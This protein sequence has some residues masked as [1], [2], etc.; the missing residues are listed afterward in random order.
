[1][2]RFTVMIRLVHNASPEKGD[3]LDEEALRW[4]VRLSSGETTRDDHEDFRSW[5]DQSASHA[6]ALARART[7][8]L[9]L[10]TAMPILEQRQGWRYGLRRSVVQLVAVAAVLLLCVNLGSQYWFEWRFDHVTAPGER[11]LLTLADG[12]RILM[13]GGTALNI[14]S[15]RGVRRIELSR[16][17]AL[18]GVRHDPHTP[19]VVNAG[20]AQFRDVGTIF[21]VSRAGDGERLVVSHGVVEASSDDR[22]AVVRAGQSV[23]VVAARL[24]PVRAVDPAVELAWA[25]GRLIVEDQPLRDI[26]TALGP[27]Y[28]GRIILLN[29]EIGRQR[30]SA[31]IDLNHIDGWLSALAQMRGLT[32]RHIAGYTL[33]N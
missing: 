24:Q 15:M 31:D 17:E 29:G 28:A 11:K 19:F 1:V 3:G 7:L 12:S 27:H 9:Q 32:T 6:A 10:G 16:G 2:E 22:R 33:L 8:W 5:R 18:F 23:S 13:R 26:L 20:G 30:M 14:N 21:A 4:V 25:R